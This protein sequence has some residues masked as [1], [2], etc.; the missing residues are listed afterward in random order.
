MQVV[1]T[2]AKRGADDRE[3][4]RNEVFKSSFSAFHWTVVNQ[5]MAKRLK[6]ERVVKIAEAGYQ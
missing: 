1:V 3:V 5:A 4:L 6:G 2:F